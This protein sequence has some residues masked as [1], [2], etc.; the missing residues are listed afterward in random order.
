KRLLKVG[1]ETARVEAAIGGKTLQMAAANGFAE[2]FEE[3]S[4]ELL[5]DFSKGCFNLV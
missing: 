3:V 1:K 5:A 2:G 4:E